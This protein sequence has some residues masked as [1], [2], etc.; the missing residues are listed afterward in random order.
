MAIVGFE[1]DPGSPPGAG[2]FTDDT[3]Y[4]SPLLFNPALAQSVGGA[5]GV[6]MPSFALP[7]A[8]P[9]LRT[10][11]ETFALP[12]ASDAGGAPPAA[13]ASLPD[14]RTFNPVVGFNGT[15]P[16]VGAGP[17]A[18]QVTAPAAQIAAATKAL[19]G[20]AQEKAPLP[21]GT[22]QTGPLDVVRAVQSEMGA[23]TPG[24]SSTSRTVQQ[25]VRLNPADVAAHEAEVRSGQAAEF[26]GQKKVIEAQTGMVQAAAD[27]KAELERQ[28]ATDRANQAAADD[29]AG[30]LRRESDQ[31]AQ[32]A[33]EKKI[34][35][36]RLFS[37]S[38]IW[39]GVLASVSQALGAYAAVISKT[40]NF[41]QQIVSN[42]VDRDVQAQREEAD[43]ARGRATNAYQKFRDAGLDAREASSALKLTLG[44]IYQSTL[45]GYDAT[46]LSAEAQKNLGTMQKTAAEFNQKTWLE[47]QQ[48]TKDRV[49]TTTSAT[50]GTPGRRV[51]TMDAAVVAREKG[52]I[53]P[54][55]QRQV[56]RQG[57][58]PE[59]A[60]KTGALMVPSGVGSGQIKASTPEEARKLREEAGMVDT[61]T[62]A[63]DRMAANARNS[64]W[65]QG[66][67]PSKEAVAKRNE[68]T[69]DVENAVNT[70]NTLQ[71]Q[72]VVRGEDIQRYH[73][74][75]GNVGSVGAAEAARELGDLARRM[76]QN[77]IRAQL[78]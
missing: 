20:L 72:G 31:L 8:G 11:Q 21:G 58:S 48:A 60:K 77:K 57:E 53:T 23:G 10:A 28:A 71:G 47:I 74:L 46:K 56:L 73:D 69:L 55:E 43:A 54:E 64:S 62:Q 39:A 6:R 42:A 45:M 17:M 68:W 27:H 52:L 75:L 76:Y 78:P 41:A 3:G 33:A 24:T 67:N 36:S 18:S 14:A 22:P 59:E 7:P 66:V 4:R 44:Q 2:F 70:L 61:A 37:G 40:P 65:F 19:G 34:D 29:R 15:K 38:H 30:A 13:P 25:G 49:S 1:Q 9:D 35:P 63:A 50:G 51:S 12:G 32:A 26:E 16:I 5:G